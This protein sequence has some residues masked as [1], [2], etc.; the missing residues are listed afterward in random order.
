MLAFLEQLGGQLGPWFYLIA[1]GLAFGEAAVMVGLVL[2]GEAALAPAAAASPDS[3]QPVQRMAADHD[4][5]QPLERHR[6]KRIQ[7]DPYPDFN[8]VTQMESKQMP[9]AGL[10]L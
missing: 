10:T 5:R 1:G 2:P 3:R 7:D 8:Q 6:L 9:A 4:D